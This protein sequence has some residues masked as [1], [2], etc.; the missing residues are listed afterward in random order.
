MYQV[1]VYG[2]P[3]CRKIL[4]DGLTVRMGIRLDVRVV[5]EYFKCT[6]CTHGFVLLRR[7]SDCTFVHHCFVCACL[8]MCVY[9][10]VGKSG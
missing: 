2:A 5:H 7:S 4:S 1:L 9:V 8:H 6:G 3:L 10:N